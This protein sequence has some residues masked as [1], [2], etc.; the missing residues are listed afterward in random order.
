MHVVSHGRC[1]KMDEVQ[2]TQP[3]MDASAGSRLEH[4][5]LAFLLGPLPLFWII[6]F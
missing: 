5:A 2:V 3:S 1:K 4:S 6:L